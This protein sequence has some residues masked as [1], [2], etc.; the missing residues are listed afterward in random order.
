M[1]IDVLIVIQFQA[2]RE[3][4]NSIKERNWCCIKE[5]NRNR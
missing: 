1:K 4:N 3:I 5:T 2:L